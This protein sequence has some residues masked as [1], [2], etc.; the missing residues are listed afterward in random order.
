MREAN[1]ERNLVSLLI[2]ELRKRRVLRKRVSKKHRGYNLEEFK[3]IIGIRA[4]AYGT[5]GGFY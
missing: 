4:S 3:K 1:S 5:Q 2:P